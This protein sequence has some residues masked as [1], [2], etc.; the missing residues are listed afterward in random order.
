MT[1]TPLTRA[2]ATGWRETSLHA[3]VLGFLDALRGDA[4]LHLSHFGQTPEGR[5]LPLVVASARGLHTPEAAHA[6]GLPVVLVICGI[7][8]GEV[9]G[10]EAMLMLLRD[11]LGSSAGD[12]LEHLT[13]VVV[14]LFNP[15]GND[16]IDPANRAMCLAKLEG[17][18]GPITGV[19]T[20]TNAAGINLNR[21]Y[22]RQDA[23]EMRLLA[24]HVWQ[25]WTP[26]LTVDCHATNGS[27]HRYDLTYDTPHTT[28]SGPAAPIAW[29]RQTF[30][31][32]VTARLRA[33]TGRET[34]FYGNFVRDEGGDGPGW[35]TYTHHPRFGSNYRGLSGRM[36]ILAECYSY[37]SFPERVATTYGFLWQVLHLAAE[38]GAEIR[39]LVLT[40][41]RPPDQIAVR[42]RLEADPDPVPI[43]TREPY[44]LD[45]DPITVTVPHYCRFV[46]EVVVKRPL[47]YAVPEALVPRLEGH[48][49]QITRLDRA[50]PAELDQATLG[51]ALPT[52]S[53]RI[54][55]STAGEAL[56]AVDWQRRATTLPSGT[57]LLYTDQPCGALATYLL[58]PE[59]DDGLLACGW[60]PPLPDGAVWP[61]LRVL[62]I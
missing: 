42:A 15:D 8:A 37:L 3:H 19:G 31:P 5:A 30:L 45:G 13:L 41:Q 7:H 33:A 34:W 62:G 40:H 48:G 39:D 51:P 28:A 10:K 14:P 56:R 36:D 29:V 50:T 20:R 11:L 52:P 6:S 4:R 61:V 44:A 17:Q 21:D 47:A 58:E 59:S 27:I 38:R 2:E 49:L 57:P 1:T 32:Q 24:R 53:R 26:H 18:D 55:E 60:L 16:R 35:M 23:E 46:G 12:L 54:L 25:R 9:E 43:L 22:M